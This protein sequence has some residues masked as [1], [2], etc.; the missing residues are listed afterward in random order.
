MSDYPDTNRM[1][2]NSMAADMSPVTR[3]VIELAVQQQ[4]AAARC[5]SSPAVSSRSA[6]AR[7]RPQPAA[8]HPN[9][10]QTSQ[11]GRS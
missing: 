1:G 7:T 4:K 6:P 2:A 9:R 8:A 3:R 5:L 11:H 10:D